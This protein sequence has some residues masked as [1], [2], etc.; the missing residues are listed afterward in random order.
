MNNRPDYQV[1]ANDLHDV[2]HFVHINFGVPKYLHCFI[3]GLIQCNAWCQTVASERSVCNECDSH[4]WSHSCYMYVCHE[5][6]HGI[7]LPGCRIPQ[8]GYLVVDLLHGV[9][10]N[11]LASAI[12]RK[13]G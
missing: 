12:M 1:I 10:S 7:K 13:C 3:M 2:Q 5:R 8:D 11:P 9:R 4:E 6:S